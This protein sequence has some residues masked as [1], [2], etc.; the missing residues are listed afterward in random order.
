[1]FCFSSFG[2]HDARI[3]RVHR[4]HSN[5]G[6]APWLPPTMRLMLAG[7]FEGLRVPWAART[8]LHLR[9]SPCHHATISS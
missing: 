6:N 3:T 1:M 7:V 5:A 2:C 4:F 9:A 8:K